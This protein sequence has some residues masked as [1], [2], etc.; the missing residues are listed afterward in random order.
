[1]VKLGKKTGAD[2]FIHLGGRFQA[3]AQVLGN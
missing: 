2:S 3:P 1:M